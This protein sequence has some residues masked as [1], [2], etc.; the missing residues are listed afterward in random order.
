MIPPTV[1]TMAPT[2]TGMLE[3]LDKDGSRSPVADELISDVAVEL[4]PDEVVELIV[5]L[6]AM[7][8]GGVEYI[9]WTP[10]GTPILSGQPIHVRVGPRLG[11]AW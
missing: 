10:G 3:P 1:P 7:A 9:V 2:M 4:I 5:E 6:V 8:A 11:D